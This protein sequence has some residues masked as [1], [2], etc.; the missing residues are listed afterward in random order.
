MTANLET[1]SKFVTTLVVHFRVRFDHEAEQ[2]EWV[3][4]ISEAISGYDASVLDR[5]A[6]RIIDTRT[7]RRFP[8][9]SEIRKACAT[10]V[11]EDRAREAA[12]KL[13]LAERPQ[14]QHPYSRDRWEFAKHL[15]RCEIGRNAARDGWSLGLFNFALRNGRLPDGREIQDVKHA[16]VAFDS[17]YAA[18]VRRAAGPLSRPLARLGDS[19]VSRAK[20][21][22]A[23]IE[24]GI[25]FDGYDEAAWPAP[26]R[27]TPVEPI[28]AR[29]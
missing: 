28:D 14:G 1:I 12:G 16:A 5:A 2:R 29:E 21:L 7:D 26:P 6:Q 25:W 18:C 24:R 9:V 20:K 8:L 15:L 4:S 22:N 17:D 10:V 3:R 27:R 23:W 13:A 19:M 11:A